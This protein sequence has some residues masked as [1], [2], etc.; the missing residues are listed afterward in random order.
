[1]DIS[2][3]QNV[4][5]IITVN[6]GKPDTTLQFIKSIP[7]QKN[8]ELWIEDNQSTSNSFKTLVDAQSKE[9]LNISIFPHKQNH[10]YWGA[11]NKGLSRLPERIE[12]W[13]RWII[14]CN[15]DILMADDFFAQLERIDHQQNCII[16]PAILSN[17]KNKDL[18]PFFDKP[19]S[20]L[21]KLYY[22]MV[23]SNRLLGRITQKVGS[24]I[25][26]IWRDFKINHRLQRSI[27]APHGACMIFSSEFFKKG[28]YIDVG[29]K[30]FGEE[31]STAEIAKQVGTS[32]QYHPQLIVEHTD[33]YSTGELHWRDLYNI[34][35]ETYHY[36]NKT[37]QF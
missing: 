5:L 25:N 23:Y 6:Y 14:V 1:M 18:N 10:Y 22:K 2:N 4:N 17:E 13:P 7:V 20:R 34:S 32:I 27:Y 24:V 21:E 36:L 28:G 30:M 35:K 19:L 29:F 3:L 26:K 16:A 33:H 12:D 11:F 15:N 31:L 8:I 37:Y 9:P